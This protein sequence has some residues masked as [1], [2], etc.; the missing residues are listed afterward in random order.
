[1]TTKLPL[2]FSLINVVTPN[3]VLLRFWLTPFSL[4]DPVSNRVTLIKLSP[5]D[6]ES[7][8]RRRFT[9]TE[10]PRTLIRCS[11]IGSAWGLSWPCHVDVV[12]RKDRGPVRGASRVRKTLAKTTRIVDKLLP[13]LRLPSIPEVFRPFG[14]H[15]LYG[16]GGEGSSA[17][18]LVNALCAHA[19]N[20][21]K[22]GGCSVVVTEVANR[23]PLKVGVPHWKMLSCD[24]DIWCIKRLGK[25]TVTGLSVTGL[26]HHL[27]FPYL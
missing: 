3:S 11:I 24:E 2:I 9:T 18:K 25:T 22:E 26:N 20:L 19:H 5:S 15:F 4:T 6:A 16:L 14:L 8:Y 7:L 1:M 10:F 13:F 17:A 12:T 27:D 23:E 21:A